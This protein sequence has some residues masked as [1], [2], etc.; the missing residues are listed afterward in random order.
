MKK[1]QIIKFLEKNLRLDV[2]LQTVHLLLP[3]PSEW[4][5]TDVSF[6]SNM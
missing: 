4:S 5:N 6:Q 3:L 1:K 2:F